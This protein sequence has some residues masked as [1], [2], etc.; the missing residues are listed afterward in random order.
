MTLGELITFLKNR[1][2]NIVS[3][4]GFGSPHSYRG[5]YEQLAFEPMPNRTVAQMLSDAEYAL[6]RTFC[7]YKGGDFTMKEYTPVWLANYGQCGEEI[8]RTLLEYMCG[9]HPK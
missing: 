8:G 2:P 1:D 9:E 7:G 5:Y 6:G 3:P 4:L